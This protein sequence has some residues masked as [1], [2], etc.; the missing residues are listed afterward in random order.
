MSDKFFH[1]KALAIKPPSL[2]VGGF[3]AWFSVEH[4]PSPMMLFWLASTMI[5]NLVT[6]VAKSWA[7]GEFTTARGFEKSAIKI[8]VYTCVVVAVVILVNMVQSI[9]GYTK[10]NFGIAIDSAM[11]FLVWIELYSVFENVSIIYPK[12]PLTRYFILPILKLLRS[13]LKNG[14][15][16]N[17]KSDDNASDQHN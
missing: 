17:D 5:I 15:L 16:D 9:S 6:G 1:F 12:S 8:I 2:L 11:G 10:F 14:P 3:F 4:I 13:R 7:K